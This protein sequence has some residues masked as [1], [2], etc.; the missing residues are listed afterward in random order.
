[1]LRVDVCAVVP[2][3][4]TKLIIRNVARNKPYVAAFNLRGMCSKTLNRAVCKNSSISGD[5]MCDFIPFK[6][7]A[8]T[9]FALLHF[10]YFILGIITII[11]IVLHNI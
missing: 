1:M 6:R 7:P 11:T 8:E 10:F 5:L 2:S 4:A 3:G 9:V